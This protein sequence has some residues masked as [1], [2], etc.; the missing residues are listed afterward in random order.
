MNDTALEVH[1]FNN[2]KGTIGI[3]KVQTAYDGIQYRISSVDGFL[4]HMDVQQVV[5]WGARFPEAAG[6]A[7]FGKPV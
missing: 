5:A 1:W 2:S 4:Q 6:E 3:A 7:I